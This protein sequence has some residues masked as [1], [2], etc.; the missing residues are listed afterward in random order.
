MPNIKGTSIVNLR[1]YFKKQP[2][3]KERLLLERL[4]PELQKIYLTAVTTTWT[5][6]QLQGQF[7]EACADVI[8]PGHPERYILLGKLIAEA[9]YSGVYKIFLRIPKMEFVIKRWPVIWQVH[10]DTGKPS[11]Q[12]YREGHI[13]FTVEDLPVLP[14]AT[15]YVVCGH[16]LKITELV[17]VKSCQVIHEDKDP[18]AWR[19]LVSWTF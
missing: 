3:E 6:E 19:W 2:P 11:Y 9:T 1:N 15:R 8:F 5:P 12:N 14:A 10:H 17:G 4:T 16:I 18:H 7:Y 13:E